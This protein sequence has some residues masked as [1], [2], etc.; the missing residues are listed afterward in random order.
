[1][2]LQSVTSVP[3]KSLEIAHRVGYVRPGYDADIVV[4]NSHPLSV[5]ATALQVY[6]DGRATLDPKGVA[7]SGV[8]SEKDKEFKSIIQKTN[9]PSTERQEICEL[10]EKSGARITITGIT[11]SYLDDTSP[12]TKD[13]NAT[14][15]IENGKIIC[16]ASHK[17]CSSLIMTT[18]PTINLKNGYVLPGLTAVSVSLGLTEIALDSGTSDGSVGISSSSLDPENVVYAK[19]GIHL[20]GRGFARARIGGITKAISAPVSNGFAGGVSVGVL[21][22]G[23]KNI[24]EGGVFQEDVALHFGIGQ[25]AKGL[26]SRP[27][28]YS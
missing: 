8:V 7:E 28:E 20:E 19:Y 13:G 15:V 10:V 16:F 24:L 27:C 14:M 18:G 5:G 21:T 9:L 17:D 1:L 4:W 25:S 2:A 3:A 26:K 23:K 22:S 6:I 12:A 11:E